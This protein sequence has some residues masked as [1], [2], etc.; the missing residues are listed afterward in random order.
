METVRK[1]DTPALSQHILD[2]QNK[3]LTHAKRGSVVLDKLY[4]T[5]KELNTI[6]DKWI[7]IGG[8]PPLV[9]ADFSAWMGKRIQTIEEHQEALVDIYQD[10]IEL[11]NVLSEIAVLFLKEDVV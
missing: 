1:M 5:E 3:Q 6:L 11:S 7:N 4:S 9:A 10:H 8:I 2:I